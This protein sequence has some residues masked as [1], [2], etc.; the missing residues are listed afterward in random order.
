MKRT[1]KIK[2][3][4]VKAAFLC[5]GLAAFDQSIEAGAFREMANV[6]R[7]HCFKDGPDDAGADENSA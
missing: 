1:V 7:A 6:V 2:M 5:A 3:Y 4:S